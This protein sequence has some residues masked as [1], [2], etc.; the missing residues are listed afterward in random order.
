MDTWFPTTTATPLGS[1]WLAVSNI[2][3]QLNALEA[4]LAE[5][6][7]LPL[8]GIIA[9]GDHCFGGPDPFAVW[10]RLR[11]LEV[12]MV[13]GKTDLALGTLKENQVTFS[14]KNDENRWRAF[15]AT[16]DALGDVVCR[17][18]AELPKTEVVSLDDQSGIMVQH[19]LPAEERRGAFFKGRGL[20]EEDDLKALTNCVAEDVLV[21]GS[22]ETPFQ[23]TLVHEQTQALLVVAPGSVGAQTASQMRHLAAH[24]VLIQAFSDGVVRAAPRSISFSAVE[25]RNVG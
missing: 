18:L 3:G 22:L 25:V 12:H 7:K 2:R 20:P 21:F 24:A 5:V 14:S 4:V 6:S 17:R 13:R 10:R 15:M 19:V 8:A 1:P 9:A 16:R 23:Q 11:E